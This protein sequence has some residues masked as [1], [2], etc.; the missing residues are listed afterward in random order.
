[1]TSNSFLAFTAAL[2][3]SFLGFA[4]L[5]RK[6]PSV[7][8]WSFFAGMQALAIESV[9]DGITSTRSRRRKSFTDRLLLPSQGPFLQVVGCFS[10]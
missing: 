7:A 8:S 9:F 4:A 1:V 2:F 10:A 5:V 6:A 3:G